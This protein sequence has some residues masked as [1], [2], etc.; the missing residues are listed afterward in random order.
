MKEIIP[1]YQLEEINDQNQSLNDAFFTDEKLFA[2]ANKL[3]KP[4]RSNYYGLGICVSGTATLVSNLDHYLVQPNSIVAMSPQVIKQWKNVS[5]DFETL[6]LFFTKAFFSK[7]F[8]HQNY[9]DQFQFF[10]Q[11][12]QHVNQFSADDTTTVLQLF[13]TIKSHINR[14]HAYQNEILASYFNILLLEYQI[15]F[16]QLHFKNSYKK[17]RSQQLVETF[18]NLLNSHFQQQRSVQ[19]YA[20]KL[21]ITPKYLTEILKQETGKTA[22]EWINELLILEAK[23]LLSNPQLQ[24]LQ[25]AEAL[26]FPDASTFGKFFKN[27]SGTSPLQYRKTL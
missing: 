23:V 17:N 18:K 11:N 15:L 5:E 8:A 1:T 16:E 26:H 25:V 19:F 12:A 14:S 27:L 2:L 7:I 20:D 10:D 6:T 13:Q 9:L 4:Y 3:N 22:S 24:I 21:F